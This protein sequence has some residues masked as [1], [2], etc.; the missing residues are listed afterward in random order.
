MFFIP[1]W[2]STT[3]PTMQLMQSLAW[4]FSRTNNEP[5]EKNDLERELQKSL[6]AARHG[7]W[8]ADEFF[9]HHPTGMMLDH[10]EL[11]DAIDNYLALLVYV[12]VTGP[13]LLRTD[14]V[15]YLK[16]RLELREFAINIE[17]LGHSPRVIEFLAFR[18]P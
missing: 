14:I 17:R 3:S 13:R 16:N 2:S 15:S 6:E 1:I 4:V 11:V 9:A 8:G 5:T 18:Q 12:R 10:P 7:F